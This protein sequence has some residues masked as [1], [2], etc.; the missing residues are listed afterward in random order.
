[1]TRVSL[2][3]SPGLADSHSSAL[4]PSEPCCLTLESAVRLILTQDSGAEMA[5]T[6]L[7]VGNLEWIRWGSVPSTWYITLGMGVAV[8]LEASM[9]LSAALGGEASG[10]IFP[11]H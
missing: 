1:M 10:I 5:A 8:F 6:T 2:S 3:P 11:V 4:A 7:L 9:L